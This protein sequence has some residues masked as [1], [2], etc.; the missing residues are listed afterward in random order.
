MNQGET[1]IFRFF[2]QLYVQTR[3]AHAWILFAQVYTDFCFSACVVASYIFAF[4]RFDEMLEQY[5]SH[6]VPMRVSMPP[7]PIP[8][9]LE[10][11]DKELRE[12]LKNRG[13]IEF[14]PDDSPDLFATDLENF[15]ERSGD[16]MRVL[17]SKKL[18]SF[19]SIAELHMS[20]EGIYGP[21]GFAQVFADGFGYNV[22]VVCVIIA[23]PPKMRSLTITAVI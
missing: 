22:S 1:S 21:D 19:A 2:V 9:H 12:H 23:F 17:N 16:M 13:F 7:G 8:Q 10:G 14:S 20:D 5:K 15:H 4:C 11:K 6:N 3:Y 18:T